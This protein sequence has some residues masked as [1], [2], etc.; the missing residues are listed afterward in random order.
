MTVRDV[1]EAVDSLAPP[2]LAYP[3]DRAGLSIGDPAAKVSSVLVTLTVSRAQLIVSHHP[4]VWEPLLRLR[5]DDRRTRLC[6]AIV[7]ANMACYAAHTNLDLVPG[8]VN[9]VLADCIGLKN[10]RPLLPVEHARQVKLVT[11]VPESHLV[12]VRA[13]VCEAGAGIIG[14]YTYCSFSTPGMGTFLP[15]DKAR[16]FSGHKQILNEEPERRFEVLA[17]KACLDR[18]LAA[19]RQAHPYEE[20][21]YDIVT[22]ENCDRSV[23]LG[24]CGELDAPQPLEAFARRV[25]AVLKADHVRLVGDR[26]RKIRRIAVIGGSG[27]GEVGNIPGNVD[28][29]V[30]GDVDYHDAL[31]A[32]ERGLAVI[33]AGHCATERPVVPALAKYLKAK[34]PDLKIATCIES[35]PFQAV[36][37]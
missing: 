35:E 36:V 10:V 2:A 15:S 24:A 3:W 18:I 31:A 14:E 5:T 16:P 33:D 29:L 30:T 27:G 12:A 34:L 20:P 19:M 32:Q 37:K 26:K 7:Q 9:A 13:A 21:A 22:L 28:A 1:C 25:R 11:F 8:G 23:G 6:L 4:L 17:P